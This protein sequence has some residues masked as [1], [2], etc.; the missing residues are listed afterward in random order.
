[1]SETPKR[2]GRP[3]KD[4]ATHKRH[5]A[6][7]LTDAEYARLEELATAAGMKPSKYLVVTLKLDQPA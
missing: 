6:F 5:R 3:F 1:M 2:A 7:S 4:P